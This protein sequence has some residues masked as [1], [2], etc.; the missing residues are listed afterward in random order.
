MRHEPVQATT[1]CQPLV[2]R[3]LRFVIV[4]MNTYFAQRLCQFSGT[5]PF[6]RS[7]SQKQV[8]YLLVKLAGISKHTVKAS[9][10]IQSEDST[11]ECANIRKL[12]QMRQCGSESLMT[13]P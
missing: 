3:A 2:C 6:F 4:H 8:M 1:P 12:V 13:T 9:L 10:H 11:A 7:A 5:E